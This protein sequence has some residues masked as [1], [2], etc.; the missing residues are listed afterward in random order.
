L[1][2]EPGDRDELRPVDEVVDD[3]VERLPLVGAFG[4]GLVGPGFP[5]L[6]GTGTVRICGRRRGLLGG[7]DEPGF[8]ALD[9]KLCSTNPAISRST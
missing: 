6:G 9:P 8:S 5:A 1:L 7:T 2:H 3:I 4:L